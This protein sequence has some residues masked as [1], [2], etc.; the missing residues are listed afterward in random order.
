M[1]ALTVEER[2]CIA[3]LEAEDRCRGGFERVFPSVDGFMYRQFFDE[4]RPLNELMNQYLVQYSISTYQ[5]SR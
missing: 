3:E 5:D 4:L 1:A 2:R